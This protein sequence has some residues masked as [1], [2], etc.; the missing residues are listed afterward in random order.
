[1]MILNKIEDISTA[2]SSKIFFKLENEKSL[3]IFVSNVLKFHNL[4]TNCHVIKQNTFYITYITRV[5]TR[6]NFNRLKN[7]NPEVMQHNNT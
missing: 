1:M 7:L 4:K 3:Q 5:L 2:I 6:L